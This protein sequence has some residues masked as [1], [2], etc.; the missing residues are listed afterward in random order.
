MERTKK[1]REEMGLQK[2][3]SAKPINT[4]VTR[5]NTLSG[6]NYQMQ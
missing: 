6:P 5:Q 3:D 4:E 1:L 2:D